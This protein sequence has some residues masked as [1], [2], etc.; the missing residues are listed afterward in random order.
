MIWVSDVRFM[1]IHY[2]LVISIYDIYVLRVK[3]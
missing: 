2:N 3:I 1:G